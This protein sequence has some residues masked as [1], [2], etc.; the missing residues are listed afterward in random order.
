M[1][2]FSFIADDAIQIGKTAILFSLHLFEEKYNTLQT[3]LLQKQKIR[4]NIQRFARER[5]GCRG[6]T[7][8]HSSKGKA[9]KSSLQE[10]GVWN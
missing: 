9:I 8:T 10:S 1:K 4:T 7:N 3:S 2:H 5:G 6:M